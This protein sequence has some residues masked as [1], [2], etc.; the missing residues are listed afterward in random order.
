VAPS[1]FAKSSLLADEEVAITVAPRAEA[2]YS[3]QYAKL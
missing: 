2:I 3:V 1:D